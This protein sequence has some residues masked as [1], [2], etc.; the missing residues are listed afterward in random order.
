MQLC[1]F[2][3]K[4]V[5]GERAEVIELQVLT[6]Y[7]RASSITYKVVVLVASEASEYETLKI[8]L[9]EDGLPS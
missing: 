3:L 6:G 8:L 4:A 9:S 2:G 1:F 7:S 5:L